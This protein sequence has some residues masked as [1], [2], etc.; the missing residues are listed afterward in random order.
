MLHLVPKE[1]VHYY[2]SRFVLDLGLTTIKVAACE[3]LGC[4]HHP[5]YGNTSEHPCTLHPLHEQTIKNPSILH[6][7]CL[8]QK[9]SPEF[10]F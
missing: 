6:I 8:F 7:I 3:A 5:Y 10:S 2:L 9:L 1:S 4:P